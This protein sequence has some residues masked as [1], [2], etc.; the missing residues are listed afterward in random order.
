M[1][2]RFSNRWPLIV[3]AIFCV[4]AAGL[5]VITF[6]AQTQLRSAADVR[7]VADNVRQASALSDFG[8]DLLSGAIDL[9]ECP[10]IETYLANK[11]LGMS[12]R[13]G[14]NTSLEAIEER[15]RQ[16]AEKK[17]VRG[18]NVY[19]RIVLFDELGEVLADTMP[20]NPPPQF[21]N[22]VKEKP[23]QAIDRDTR[24][25]V[26]TA[27]VIYKGYFSGTIVAL[28]NVDQFSRYLPSFD[29][30]AR[31]G[32]ILML[33]D[34]HELPVNG[35]IKTLDE[36]L[37]KTL[38]SLPENSLVA[39]EPMHLG[40]DIETSGEFKDSLAVK[41]PLPGMHLSLVSI[42]PRDVVYGHIT[43]RI[44]LYSA[45][46]FPLIILFA[47]IMFDRLSRRTEKLQEEF[48]SSDK[49]RS[50]LQDIN[51]AL[52]QEISQREAVEKELREKS[53][54]LEKT[55]SDL[56]V[57]MVRA[58]ESSRAKS[59]FLATM[60]HEIRTP[61][62][63]I[64]GMTDLALDT[65]LSEEQ[66]EYLQTVRL[67]SNSLLAI[68]NDILDFS[69]IEAGKLL[70][71]KIPYD[72]HRMMA[73]TLKVL[74]LRAH[75]KGLE[76]VC[77]IASDVPIRLLG[78]PGRIRQILINLVGNAIK[79]TE[80]G[81]IV[82][83]AMLES[84]NADTCSLHIMVSDTGIGIA[85]D[86]QQLIFEAFSQE[87]GSISRKY[88]GTGLGLSI[89]NRLVEMM[90]GRMWVESEPQLGSAFHFT[91]SQD[92]DHSQYVTPDLLGVESLEGRRV[93]VVDDN[94]T[95]RR[96]I[97]GLLNK[98]KII[99]DEAQSGKAA[100]EVVV[101]SDIKYDCILLDMQMPE[102]DG[103]SVAEYLLAPPRRSGVPP[104]LLLT[105]AGTKGDSQR[106]KEMGICGYFTKPILADDLLQVLLNALGHSAK[107]SPKMELFTRHTLKES[108]TILSVLL[109]EDN[110]I[111]QRV[112][113]R[114]LEKAGHQVSTAMNGIEA[115][116]LFD[117]RRFDVI[118][119][120]MQMPE[121]D[122]LEAT[123]H[124]R[125]RESVNGVRTPIIAMTANVMQG[126][127]EICLNAGM[128]DYIAK[129]VKASELIDKLAAIAANKRIALT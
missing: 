37:V 31:Y 96:V 38:S 117:I 77:D 55:T 61:M 13:Y 42:Q 51:Q 40:M 44:I 97:C 26:T 29:G 23:V 32:E 120:D 116:N 94:T 95:N 39:L 119:M 84:I 5:L 121:M 81:E 125:E 93:L 78:D 74:S 45:G 102:M 25:I 63:G 67:S 18:E 15:F 24:Q 87:D 47:A 34:G 128:D 90:Q 9:A 75:E 53:S 35:N 69:K 27:P 7:I 14:L 71:E 3:A 65:A 64:I 80:H 10:E 110:P 108:T 56:R 8:T 19:N 98:W 66:R 48:I 57:S 107:D 33:D 28:A 20:E 91:I 41:S 16:Q 101:K 99:A 122:G 118:L 59:E 112:A 115:L 52:S 4:Y 72:F 21:L 43:S 86:K 12:L 127:K 58:E 109:V 46:A 123:R 22:A 85:K 88:G 49:R 70:I 83:R 1:P 104:I 126:D 79:F 6:R 30:Q 17:K 76:L 103:F 111:N 113:S 68:I 60:S 105:S 73:E 36:K 82:A 62:N 50:E 100:I 114:I 106:C 89:S 124:I 92:L 129:P 11:A 54:Q 2:L